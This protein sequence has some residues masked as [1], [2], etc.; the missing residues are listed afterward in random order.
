[1]TAIHRGSDKRN[2]SVY[3]FYVTQPSIENTSG[4]PFACS[5]FTSMPLFVAGRVCQR[6]CGWA[7]NLWYAVQGLK[8]WIRATQRIVCLLCNEDSPAV[9]AKGYGLTDPLMPTIGAS[10]P[11]LNLKPWSGATSYVQPRPLNN[12][13]Q[14]GL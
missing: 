12:G 2:V 14:K 13:P 4:L 5:F 3:I 6:V 1:M 7:L 11:L 9:A 10:D 8:G